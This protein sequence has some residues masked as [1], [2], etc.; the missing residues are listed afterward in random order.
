MPLP[1]HSASAPFT[2][3]DKLIAVLVDSLV[4]PIPHGARV[5]IGVLPFVS[6]EK[7][8][9]EEAGSEGRAIAEKIIIALVGHPGRYSVVDRLDYQK[10]LGEIALSQTGVTETTIEI[11]LGRFMTA[12]YLIS[13]TI[14][15]VMGQSAIRA[16]MVKVESGEIVSASQS[17]IGTSVLSQAA[18]ELF[19]EQQSVLSYTFR[20]AVVPGWGQFYAQQPVRGAI[21][22]VLGIGGAS[23]SVYSWVSTA[24]RK[25]ERDEF[26]EFVN[27]NSGR[28][29]LEDMSGY[30]IGTD[31][32]I[33]WFGAEKGRYHDEYQKMLTTAKIA[34]AATAGVWILNMIDAS[35]AGRQKRRAIQ[36]Y[37]SATLEAVGTGLTYTY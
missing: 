18:T 20:S 22:F 7:G 27:T 12:D 4:S 8:L 14:S 30:A 15:A 31:G 13:G 17:V 28:S 36:L 2:D 23:V 9:L 11:E 3:I 24:N 26:S 25:N 21:S 37:F 10:A 35:F 16:K 34:T 5:K 1:S 6:G 19:S 32:F 29:R 33:R